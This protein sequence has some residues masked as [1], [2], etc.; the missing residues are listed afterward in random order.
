MERKTIRKR[1]SFRQPELPAKAMMEVD[2][3][4]MPK[5][6]KNVE[7]KISN[8]VMGK[9]TEAA[10]LCAADPKV[11]KAFFEQL[12]EQYPS[13]GQPISL[14]SILPEGKRG[15]D[16]TL[17]PLPTLSKGEYR[18]MVHTL[19]LRCIEGLTISKAKSAASKQGN[20]HYV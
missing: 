8:N 14:I 7:P 4:G 18:A 11:V 9:V 10:A 13:N 5:K 19:G 2:L 12:G 20:I 17:T 3:P 16:I 6:P 1:K 15:I